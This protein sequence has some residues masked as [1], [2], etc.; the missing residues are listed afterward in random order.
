MEEKTL[1]KLFESA[2]VENWSKEALT[3]YLGD[4]MTYESAGR[5]IK[6][7]HYLFARHEIAKGEKIALLGKNSVN[8]GIIYIATVTYGAV[9]VPVLA[10]F[11]SRDV[12]YI[13]NHSDS[14]LLFVENAIYDTLDENS[15]ENLRAVFSLDN[16]AVLHSSRKNLQKEIIGDRDEYWSVHNPSVTHETFQFDPVEDHELAS[17]V[18][19]SGTTGFSKGVMLSH[20]SLAVN[21]HFAR[22]NLE[23]AAGNR[24]VSFLP[25]AH[26]YGLAFDFLYPFSVGAHITFL[27]KIPSPKIILKAFQDV[28][29]HLIITVPLVLEKIYRNQ[30]KRSIEKIST[31]ILLKTPVM[32]G[33]VRNKIR[34]KLRNALGGSFIEIIIGGAS[35]NEE[36]ELFFRSIGLE[37]TVGYGMTE[38][39][40]LISYARHSSIKPRSVG[41][42]ISYMESKI[43]DPDPGSGIGEI[44]VRGDNV[45]E[46]YYKNPEATEQVL[47]A[48]EWLHTGDLGTIDADGF[49]YIKGRSKNMILGPSGQNIYPEEIEALINY[50]P[51]IAESLVIDKNGTLVAMIYPD[52]DQVKEKDLSETGLM[53]Q[54]EANRLLLNRDLPAY[55]RISRFELYPREF[56][57][58]P[59]KKIKRYL[60]VLLSK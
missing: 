29:P 33:I 7:L 15:M 22:N 4:S 20:R 9:I 30:I 60:Y 56:E 50:M 16:L 48:D 28:Q 10:D 12:H 47:D 5:M 14:V 53:E 13:V 11:Q 45:M 59:S 46:G 58:T 25:L 27:S 32:S 38:C 41:T 17:I 42:T 40:P 1:V 26:C 36:V 21:V 35:L 39:G 43:I 49:I 55:S 57:K 23:L 44:C 54:L 52:M 18:Y 6:Y 34:T 2:I 51:F 24:I 19:T 8:W 3:N 31:R 37:F